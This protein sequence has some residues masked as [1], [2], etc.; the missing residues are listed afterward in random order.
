MAP[1]DKDTSLHELVLKLGGDKSV[2]LSSL[3][4][5]GSLALVFVRDFACPHAR[6]HLT[7]LR[8][9]KGRNLYAVVMNTEREV[10][11]LPEAIRTR[12]KFVLDPNRKLYEFF[13]ML[14]LTQEE[15]TRVAGVPNVRNGADLQQ[16]GGCVVLSPRGRIAWTY[17]SQNPADPAPVLEIERQLRL[18]SHR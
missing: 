16:L 15:A 17:Q 2:R 11:A 18:A 7:Q 14:R 5:Q 9:L 8:N 6:Q 4:E 3:L 10:L 13:G 1:T 12:L